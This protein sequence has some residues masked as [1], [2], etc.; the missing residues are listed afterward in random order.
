M[1]EVTSHKV[2]EPWLGRHRTGETRP[3]SELSRSRQS[4]QPGCWESHSR[5]GVAIIHSFIP[6]NHVS[7][8]KSK[9]KIPS[10]V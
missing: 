10:R 4:M 8:Q 3:H 5:N 1:P 2:M 6:E 7:G 9:S